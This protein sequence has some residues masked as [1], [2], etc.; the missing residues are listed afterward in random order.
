MARKRLNKKVAIIG[1]IFLVIL[2]LCVIA[3]VLHFSKD[4]LKFLSDAEVALAAKNY[5]EANRNYRRAFKYSKDDDL[6]IRI[7]FKY[8]EF[9]LINEELHEREWGKAIS[10][11]GQILN[12]DP[13]NVEAR[14]ILLKNY[15]EAADSG[16]FS[17]WQRVESSASELIEVMEAKEMEV[18]NFALLARARAMQVIAS[19]GQTSNR[20]QSLEDAISALEKV[21]ELI[22]DNVDIYLYLARAAITRGEIE[23]SRGVLGAEEEALKNTEA[24]LANAVEVAGDNPKAHTNLL[25]VKLSFVTKDEEKMQALEDEFK[26]MVE[27]FSSKAEVY[28]SLASYYLRRKD[29]LDKAIDAINKAIELDDED[30]SYVMIAANLYYRKYSVYKDKESLSKAIETARGALGLPDAQDIS[31]PRQFAS[32]R[33]KRS[34]Y[35]F[36]SSIYIQEAFAADKRE[37]EDEKQRWIGSLEKTVHEIEQILGTGDN[38]HVLKWRGMVGWAKDQSAGSLRQMYSAYQQLKATEQADALLSYTLAEA[39]KGRTTIG[40]RQEFLH[41]AITNGIR[42]YKPESL[43]DYVQV[44]YQRGGF[45]DGIRL[46]EQYEKMYPLSEKSRKLLIR[47]YIFAGMY[48]E[49]NDALAQLDPQDIEAIILKTTLLRSQVRRS[50]SV[51]TKQKP[52]T[53]Q[54]QPPSY[55]E[56]DVKRFTAEYLEMI[57]KLVDLAPEQMSIPIFACN[58]Y[59][60]QGRIDEAQRL[61]DKFLAHSPNNTQAKI[62]R[63][64]LSEPDPQKIPTERYGEIE[65]E[66]LFEIGDE[67]E[68]SVALA[69]Y[70]QS[71]NQLEKAMSEIKKA[72]EADPEENS[73]IVKLFDIAMLNKD[74]ATAEQIAEQARIL[75]LDSCE[76]NFFAARLAVAKEDYQSALR[77]LDECVEMRPL[78]AYGYYYR[79]QVN[80]A[81]GNHSEAISDAKAARRISFLDSSIAKQEAL[82]LYS[83]NARLGR[84][85]TSDQFDETKRSLI[86]AMKLNPIDWNIRGLYADYIEQRE[87]KEALIER[88]KLA[89]DFP[90]MRNNLGLGNMALRMAV[91]ETDSASKEFFYSTARSA[92]EKAYNMEPANTAVLYAYSEFYRVTGQSEKAVDLFKGQEEPRGALWRFYLRDGQYDKAKEILE[93]LYKDNAEEITVIRG[94][95]IAAQSTGDL[96]G[97]KRYSDELLKIEETSDNELMQI[98]AYLEAGLIN[99]AEIKIESFRERNPDEPKGML[100][101]AWSAMMK[102]QLEKALDLMNRNLEADPTNAMAWRLRGQVNSL[103]GDSIRAVEDLQKSKRINAN[104]MVRKELSRAYYRAGKITEA[105]GELVA[106]LEDERAPAN[107]RDMLE[108]LYLRTGM[109]KELRQL[110]Q[111][112]LEKYPESSL[113]H[114][115]AGKFALREK[116]YTYAQELFRRSWQLT[117][118]E[119]GG[120]VKAFEYYLE[121]LL[122]GGNYEELL[123]YASEYIDTPF[124]PAAYSQMAQAKFRLG[125]R[126]TAV[127]YFHKAL[128]KSEANDMYIYGILEVMAKTIGA[129]DVIKWCE[130]MIKDDED[131]IVANLTMFNLWEK[132]GEYNKALKYINKCLD[133]AR[134]DKKI[135]CK[136]AIKKANVLIAA[137]MK[138][139]DKVYLLDAIE[140]FENILEL[141]PDNNTVLNNLAY[142]LADNNEQLD[143]AVEY[144]RR[145]HESV[146]TDPSTIDTYAYTLCKTGAYSKSEEL[147]QM[148]IQIYDRRNQPV[149][150]DTYEHLGMAYEGLGRKAEAG[151]SYRQA[152][153]AAGKVISEKNKE[154][155]EESIKRVLR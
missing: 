67:V 98:R 18:D 109:K 43:L 118:M 48:S 87:P 34:L 47:G 40:A 4:P 120:N 95:M 140:Q 83:R 25:N 153:E 75:N 5:E 64:V 122:S 56:Q 26:L 89:K 135:W 146:P 96:E 148:A 123:K 51:Q 78:F 73:V 30:V 101:E 50:S 129:R 7:L 107:V 80:S 130:D 23:A 17:M 19:L 116:D 134:D 144:A 102:G 15:Y 79:S 113:W 137:Y 10:C 133:M 27:R 57:E 105:I 52:A 139:T 100:L 65:K 74:M 103:L 13:K 36:L 94:L 93:K 46:V 128:E 44:L 69:A 131:S 14:M 54:E 92:Y 111:E 110:Y 114:F 142:L 71:K 151:T 138:T 60:K 147:L 37:D 49:A 150:W 32:R 3:V 97:I 66:V 22:P 76:G 39:V 70:Y 85:V 42:T 141:Q 45:S 90:D 155:L 21:R 20:E 82:V 132:S 11:W 58:S 108:A 115:R 127:D 124:A 63:R 117:Q 12:I 86:R 38:V 152:L 53:D 91:K 84:N 143:K 29:S 28:Q 88:Q 16:I 125:S 24:I 59:V 8:S 112:T 55:T 104:P 61:I 62:Y 72:Y 154:R 136:Y 35:E 77:R 33:N 41:S 9:H 149:P 31:G 2:L 106:A 126:A 6:K 119:R 121:S 1:S 68:R 99:E 81:L 145:A